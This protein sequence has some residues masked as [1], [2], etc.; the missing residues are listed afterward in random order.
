MNLKFV[1]TISDLFGQNRKY[2]YLITEKSVTR[3][4]DKTFSTG[5]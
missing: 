1:L 3:K 2:L 5:I 4:T